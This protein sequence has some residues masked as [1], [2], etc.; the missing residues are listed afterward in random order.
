MNRLSIALAAICLVTPHLV[1]QSADV[2]GRYRA[3]YESTPVAARTMFNGRN[4]GVRQ[5]LDGSVCFPPPYYDRCIYDLSSY[6]LD[7]YRRL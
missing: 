6:S 1:A 2:Q 7:L 5:N 3:A 4:V